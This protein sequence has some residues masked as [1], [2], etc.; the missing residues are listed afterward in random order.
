[1][2]W[3]IMF[4]RLEDG[5]DANLGTVRDLLTGD[6]GGAAQAAVDTGHPR[7]VNL[8]GQYVGELSRELESVVSTARTQTRWLSDDI[9]RASLARNGVD[10]ASLKDKPC[11]SVFL[12]LPAGIELEFHSTWLRVV[13]NCALNALYR[14]G[15]ASGVPV[16]FMLSEFAQLGRLPSILAAFGQARKYSIRL[17][18]VLQNIGQIREIYGPHGAETFV[19]NSGCVLSYTAADPGTAEFASLF[20]GEQAMLTMSANNNPQGGSPSINYG[21]QMERV[22]TPGQIRELPEFHGLVW[23]F[24]QSKP[25]PVYLPPYYEMAACRRRM[26]AD[27]YFPASGS[28]LRW[29]LRLAARAMLP[30]VFIA[31][32]TLGGALLL[33]SGPSGLLALLDELRAVLPAA[34]RLW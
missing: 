29:P 9:M 32:L 30:A 19:A 12:I 21:V 11:K 27:P 20:S 23:K 28:G 10:F 31:A 5:I 16:V 4:V 17:W 3:L 22:W 8:A 24:G 34:L 18:T 26:R 15:T 1:M 13:I 14:R 25:Q 33:R 2:T 7:L 6:L